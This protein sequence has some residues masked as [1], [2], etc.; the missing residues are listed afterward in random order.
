MFRVRQRVYLDHAATTPLD[1]AVFSAMR[2]Y[3][4]KQFANPS[5]IHAR[6]RD[7]NTAL[8]DAREK[9]ARVLGCNPDEVVFTSGGTES[10]N[11]ALVGV[12][13]E[14]GFKGHVITS[15]VEH[16]SVL[17]VA[18]HL[19]ARGVSVTA[20]G[21]D[22]YGR[23][24]PRDV[25]AAIRPDTFLVS[26]MYANNEIG[27]IQSIAKIGSF[28]Q[29]QRILMH[30]DAV[31]APGL[32]PLTVNKLHVDLMSLSAHKFYGPKGAGILYV[33]RGT[34]VSPQMRGGGQERT[35]R[36]GTENVPGIIGTA[37]ALVRAER[38]QP[39][40]S[41]RLAK[42][43][44]WLIKEIQSRIPDALLTGHL[45]ERLPNSASF[46]FPGILGEHLVMRLSERGFDCST[47]SACSEGSLEPSH[48]LLACGMTKHEAQGSL[49][50]SLGSR[51]RLPH[52]KRF[53]S[54]LVEEAAKLRS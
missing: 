50:V 1:R 29:K 37:E 45:H 19:K 31:Q 23:V 5:S 8:A 24:S 44:D 54:S 36:P 43:R 40:E 7:V 42:L 18:A 39:K 9:V 17:E 51:T 14:R 6:G 48:V 2:P 11:L 26:I 22:A 52:L 35:L 38:N 46:C 16:A 15:G 3:F 32:L 21:V 49:R 28:V 10:N 4:S 13:A 41:A 25:L 47:G 53:V 33:K 34:H 30:T 12:A 20:V 27:T